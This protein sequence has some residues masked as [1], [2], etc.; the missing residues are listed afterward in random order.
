MTRIGHATHTAL[1]RLRPTWR[2]CVLG[3]GLSLAAFA[4]FALGSP[5]LS[6]QNTA[7]AKSTQAPASTSKMPWAKLTPAQQNI[8]APLA[9]EWDKLPEINQK[10]WVQI[11]ERYP[12]LKPDAQQRLQSRMVE[13]AKMTPEQRRT[14]R[15][16]YQV[17]KTVS[18]AKKAEAWQDYQKLPEDQK[19]RLAAAEKAQKKP[20]AVSALPSADPKLTK[21]A[22][23]IVRHV[24]KWEKGTMVLT[25]VTFID[26]G[27]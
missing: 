14:A 4:L 12:T 2:K 24:C 15:E 10:K 5:L 16:N 23:K 1:T 17:S 3:A 7:W 8:L 11:T 22:S 27:A 20:S 26:A 18:T 13:W 25:I 19:N 9:G 21:D 6:Q